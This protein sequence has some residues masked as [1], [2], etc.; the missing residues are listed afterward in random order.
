MVS[1][2]R[3]P[4]VRQPT[5]SRA[6]IIRR[7]SEL[8]PSRRSSLSI[9][10]V[11]V[12]AAAGLTTTELADYAV[13]RTFAATD[14]DRVVKTGV[15]TILGVLG[16]PYDKALPVTLT[17]W[18]LGLLKALYST[19]NAYYARYQRGEMEQVVKEE[20]ERSGKGEEPK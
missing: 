1:G 8:S 19:D 2:L 18:D 10:V 14:P 20:L 13:M 7:A 16:Q 5:V 15:P 12:K 9:V 4:S 6:R 3:S 17:Y 11:D